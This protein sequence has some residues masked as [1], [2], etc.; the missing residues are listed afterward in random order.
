MQTTLKVLAAMI[1]LVI[2]LL[3]ASSQA[4][5]GGR[6]TDN[7][8]LMAYVD[9]LIHPNAQTHPQQS[10]ASQIWLDEHK[11]VQSGSC[12]QK[13]C[14]ASCKYGGVCSGGGGAGSHCGCCSKTACPAW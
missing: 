9:S 3:P 10:G 6:L 7:P 14:N 2:S 1:L 5:V 12:D 8:E 4:G 13:Q 11:I